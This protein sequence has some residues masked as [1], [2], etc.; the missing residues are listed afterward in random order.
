MRHLVG[1]LVVAAVLAGV[2]SGASAAGVPTCRGLPATI[3]GTPGN[4]VIKGTPGDDVIAALG[5]NDVVKG[6][7]GD[8]V[9]CGGTGHDYLVGRFGRDVLIG[10]PQGDRVDAFSRRPTVIRGGGGAD[11]L[12]LGLSDEPGYVLDGGRGH[13]IG[14]V[15]L[16]RATADGPTVVIRRGPGDFV[17]DGLATGRY[18]GIEQLGLDERTGY[19]YYGTDA[20]DDVSV[21]DGAFPFRAETYGGD[22]VVVS[23]EGDDHIDTGRG[24]DR[25]DAGPGTDV[26]LHAERTRGCESR[27]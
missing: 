23:Y 9:V 8:D 24:F 12:F 5:G 25:V 15:S 17:R 7:G 4:D 21:A 2:P 13:D 14:D 22:D 19:E 6:R 18:L 1:P 10:G 27:G 3:V 20:A 11:I 16:G 26:C